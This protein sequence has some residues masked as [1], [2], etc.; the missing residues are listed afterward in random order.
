MAEGYALCE[1][2]AGNR[3]SQ[4]ELVALEFGFGGLRRVSRG[5]NRFDDDFIREKKVRREF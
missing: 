4:S 1:P 3:L 5:G 2:E